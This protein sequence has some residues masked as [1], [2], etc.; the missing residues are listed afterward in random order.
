[1]VKVQIVEEKDE[2]AINSPYASSASSRTSSS[3]SLSSVDSDSP[4]DESLLDRISALKDIVPPTTRHS[5][6]SKVSKTASFFKR[7]SKFAG[8]VIWVVTT[9]ALLIGLPLALIL[10]D[11]AK[12][13]AQENEMLSQQQGAQQVRSNPHSSRL[14]GRSSPSFKMVSGSSLYPPS[15]NSQKQAG[16]QNLVPPG[17]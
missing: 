1:M 8:N 5:I 17:F 6:A 16:Q 13:V 9:S 7:T 3:V 12:V 15:P 2:Q 4:V 10:E 11:E 14:P